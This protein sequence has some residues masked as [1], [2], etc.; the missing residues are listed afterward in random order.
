MN[1]VSIFN[2]SVVAMNSTSMKYYGDDYSSVPCEYYWYER[3]CLRIM[4]R[5]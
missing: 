3:Y 5:I 1:S 4:P 2:G